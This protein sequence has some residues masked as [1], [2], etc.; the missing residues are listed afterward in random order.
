[1]RLLY[2]LVT[3]HE[4]IDMQKK[5]AAVPGGP[6]KYLLCLSRLNYTDDDLLLES[7]IDPDATPFA[8]EMLDMYVSPEEGDSIHAAFNAE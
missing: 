5:L 7:G 8:A 2:H 3:K 6:Q 1:M 4:N